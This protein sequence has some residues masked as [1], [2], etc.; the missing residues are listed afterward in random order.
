MLSN[1]PRLASMEAFSK[2]RTSASPTPREWLGS[3]RRIT[4]SSGS[5]PIS[6]DPPLEFREFDRV[7]AFQALQLFPKP[8]LNRRGIQRGE[9]PDENHRHQCAARGEQL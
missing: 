6:C 2:D 3:I 9:Y 7:L 8:K 1:P 4:R 5:P